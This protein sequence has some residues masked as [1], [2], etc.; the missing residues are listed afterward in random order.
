MLIQTAQVKLFKYMGTL[1]KLVHAHAYT[2]M[3]QR[4]YSIQ[5]IAY[6]KATLN[7]LLIKLLKIVLEF[8]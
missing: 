1:W 7:Q 3:N 6:K 8:N 5:Y 2:K 4:D